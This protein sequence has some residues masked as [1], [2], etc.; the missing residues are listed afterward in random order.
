MLLRQQNTH[1]FHIHG[2]LNIQTNIYVP[3]HI[4]LFAV[5]YGIHIDIERWCL[6]YWNCSI[7]NLVEVT[8]RMLLA[9]ACFNLL[10]SMSKCLKVIFIYRARCSNLIFYIFVT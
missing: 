1:V 5:Y 4:M 3:T 6:F 2:M 8:L 9:N 7:L 10:R